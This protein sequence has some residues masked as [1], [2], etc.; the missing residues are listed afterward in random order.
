MLVGRSEQKVS[1]STM[2]PEAVAYVGA[3]EDKFLQSEQV[4]IATTHVLHAGM[5]SRTIFIP[6][7]VVITGALI[8]IET[9]LIISGSVLV[10]IGEEKPLEL[11]GYHVIPARAGRKQVFLARENTWLTMS[12]ASDAETIEEAEAEFTDETAK[13]I[14][15]KE[16]DKKIVIGEKK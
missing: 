9:T 16:R 11:S 2:S 10:W 1:L 5:Y 3:L 14:T 12:F 8:K 15:S 6:E 13:L 4:A 7:G